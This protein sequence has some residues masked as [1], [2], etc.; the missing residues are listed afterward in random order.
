MRRT[1]QNIM[2]SAWPVWKVYNSWLNITAYLNIVG[3]KSRTDITKPPLLMLF[4]LH[5]S[6]VIIPP[7]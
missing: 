4:G 2:G 5:Q 7:A 1:G 6:L 3:E